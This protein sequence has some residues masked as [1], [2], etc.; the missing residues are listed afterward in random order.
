MTFEVIS[1]NGA[2]AVVIGDVVKSAEYPGSQLF[3]QLRPELS[4][5][6][7][8]IGCLEPFDFTIGDEFE[9]VFAT[10]PLA[11]RAALLLRLLVHPMDLRF[12]IGF[13]NTM[14]ITPLRF[15]ENGEGWWLAREAI[16]SAQASERQPS[17]RALRTRFRTIDTTHETTINAFLLV[18]DFLVSRMDEIDR[19]IL[20]SLLLGQLQ[21]EIA[22][23]LGIDRS[24]VSKRVSRNGSNYLLAAYRGLDGESLMPS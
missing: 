3:E 12:G 11:I 1:S 24:A 18:H 14:K 2:V 19:K 4:R 6:S 15:A 16:E 7:T 13:G 22:L 10:P 21:T 17:L 9:G 20:A 23:Q 5:V 8:Q